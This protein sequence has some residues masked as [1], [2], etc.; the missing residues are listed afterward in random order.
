MVKI[1]SLEKFVPTDMCYLFIWSTS[2]Y[3]NIVSNFALYI[4][5]A[6]WS[7]AKDGKEYGPVLI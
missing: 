2:V 3:N 7:N 4:H 5:G 1:R 6:E